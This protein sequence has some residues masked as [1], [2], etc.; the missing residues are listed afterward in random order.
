[1]LVDQF[2]SEF[3]TPVF[4]D[5]LVPVVHPLPAMQTDQLR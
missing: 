2:A 3:G 4:I 5:Q 1:M